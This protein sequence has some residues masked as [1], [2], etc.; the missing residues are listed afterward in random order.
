[1]V[2]LNGEEMRQKLGRLLKQTS[3]EEVR[4]KKEAIK[5]DEKIS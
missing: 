2:R 4:T 3:S 5:E 1:M